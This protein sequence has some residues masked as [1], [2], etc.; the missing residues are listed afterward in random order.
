MRKTPSRKTPRGNGTP[1]QHTT[2][3]NPMLA[4]RTTSSD[5]EDG[6][7]NLS[8]VPADDL[9]TVTVR[10]PLK[11]MEDRLD[12]LGNSGDA[13]NK[14][15]RNRH[16]DADMV[17]ENSRAMPSQLSL[18]RSCLISQE[19]GAHAKEVPEVGLLWT[20]ERRHVCFIPHSVSEKLQTLLESHTT[21]AFIMLVITANSIMLAAFPPHG[22]ATHSMRTRQM[23]GQVD[24]VF[25]ALY[26]IECVLR[27]MAYGFW[28]E[29]HFGKPAYMNSGWNRLDLFV[30][31]TSI[32]SYPLESTFEQYNVRTQMFRA[33]RVLR[34]VHAF[35]FFSGI[36]ALLSTL[37]E[38][39]GMMRDVATVFAF[40][41]AFYIVLGMGLFS[42]RLRTKCL[43]PAILAASNMN[44]SE[45]TAEFNPFHW[46]GRPGDMV[47]S[48]PISLN[49]DS[50]D[51]CVIT[52]ENPRG[53]FQGYD[54]IASSLLTLIVATTGDNWQDLTFSLMD[55]ESYMAPYLYHLSINLLL[56]LVGINLFV[57]VISSTF[58][59]VRERQANAEYVESLTTMPYSDSED[60]EEMDPD[61]KSWVPEQPDGWVAPFYHLPAAEKLVSAGEFEAGVTLAIFG[62]TISLCMTHY[63]MSVDFRENLG[64][65][66]VFFTILFIAEMVIKCIGFGCQRY[67]SEPMNKIDVFINAS[68]IVGLAAQMQ[69][70]ES[71]ALR[72]FRVFRLARVARISRVLGKVESSRSL[73]KILVASWREIANL[74]LFITYCLFVFSLFGM[75]MMGDMEQFEDK[76]LFTDEASGKRINPRPLFVDFWHAFTTAFLMM[77]GDRWK[78]TMYTYMQTYGWE[79]CLFFVL[80]WIM[81]SCVML[82]LFVAVILENFVLTDSDKKRMQKEKYWRDRTKA[83]APNE[84]RIRKM[85]FKCGGC[86]QSVVLQHEDEVGIQGKA[87][88]VLGPQNY[89]RILAVYVVE[90]PFFELFIIILITI[91]S[92]MIAFEGRAGSLGEDI[93][94][95]FVMVDRTVLILFWGELLLRSV[96]CGFCLSRDAYLSDNWNK[97]DF[98]V[99]VCATLSIVLESWESVA[100]LFRL[101]RLLRPIRFLNKIQGMKRIVT[102]VAS[103]FGDL[104]GVLLMQGVLYLMFSVIG[105]SLFGGKF[106]RCTDA[107]VYGKDDCIGTYVSESGAMQNSIWDNPG[108]SFD[109]IFAALRTLVLIGTT[110]GWSECLYTAMDVTGIDRQPSVDAFPLASAYFIIFL[111]ICTFAG[112][113]LFVGVLINLF[114]TATGSALKTDAQNAWGEAQLH[115][116]K[117]K[118]TVD[119]AKYRSDNAALSKIFDM[120]THPVFDTIIT[121]L[122]LLNVIVMLS[123][124]YPEPVSAITCATEKENS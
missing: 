31:V 45:M 42:G 102:A 108:Y 89:L 10:N 78:V 99:V 19:I 119:I 110:A 17:C 98:V 44:V 51:L 69:E 76:S 8:S 66:E 52:N 77:T 121:V 11:T 53:G 59:R 74:C 14:P 96:A 30:V 55:E 32:M 71:T 28:T 64:Y 43:S 84:N 95:A 73:I 112:I 116:A 4:G 113:N 120:V 124:F 123:N 60:E 50:E 92:A 22:M 34:F 100:S 12:D 29:V 103:S 93:L 5:E 37:S 72:L 56:S 46:S 70:T 9:G 54:N 41:F 2:F 47:S 97:V 88:F 115:I 79:A 94:P 86:L 20:K 49:C 67:W 61:H 39:V 63:G 1:R 85:L 65:V 18:M 105:V 87:F 15:S 104:G 114:G 80:M 118:P 40:F 23:V 117:M 107:D 111:F 33:F 83:E 7:D 25:T 91:S 36:R 6:D 16:D 48:C 21:E 24:I 35:R 3:T 122:I 90:H 106:Y 75:H 26:T 38:A 58:A 57:V 81:C 13:Q 82:N 68:T 27:I 109:N 101:P 62:N